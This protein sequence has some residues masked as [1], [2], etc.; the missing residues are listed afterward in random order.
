MDLSRRQRAFAG[1]RGSDA[2]GRKQYRYHP[3]YRAVRDATKFARMAAFGKAL[4]SIRRRVRRDLGVRGLRR[5]K[6]LATVVRLLERTGIRVGNEE[7]ARENGSF[8]LTTL[9]ER[10]VKVRGKKLQFH[11]KGKS[12]VVHEVEPFSDPRLVEDHPPLPVHPGPGALSL[13]R[14]RRRNLPCSLRRRERLSSRGYRRRFHCQGFSYLEGNGTRRAGTGRAGLIVPQERAEEEYCGG[15]KG[16]GPACSE[17]APA[18]CRKYYVH[19]AI[20]EAYAGGTLTGALV[21]EGHRYYRREELAVLKLV[22]SYKLEALARP[23]KAA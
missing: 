20:L 12:G 22:A 17:I 9:R 15:D 11:F 13:H 23:K 21:A 2:R 10:H 7:Y 5:E 1:H 6:V 8:G 19:P 14:R 4:P 3:Q 18:T 16:G